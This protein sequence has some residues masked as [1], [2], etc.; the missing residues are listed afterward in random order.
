LGLSFWGQGLPPACVPAAATF[1]FDIRPTKWSYANILQDMP[2]YRFAI[3]QTDRPD[4]SE[5]TELADDA[6]AREQ[7]LLVIR[8][9]KKNN[10]A[11][12]NGRTIK[13]TEGD[14]Q[15]WQIP[16]IGSE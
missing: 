6:A 11:G 12:W 15:V 9:L 3:H 2:L 16:F 1:K 4:D 8:D 14:R 10:A 13:V 7:A 5:A